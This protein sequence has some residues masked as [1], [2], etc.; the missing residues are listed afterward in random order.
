[1]DVYCSATH[2]HV[3]RCTLSSNQTNYALL[4]STLTVTFVIREYQYHYN[5]KELH[6]HLWN[7]LPTWCNWVFICVLSARHG[8]GLY[9]HLQEQW[10]LQFLYICCIWCPWCSK[11]SVL[12]SV[13]VLVACCTATLVAVEHATK[14]H[15][16]QDRHLTTQRTPYAAYVKK[17]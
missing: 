11:V 15:I 7:D 1:M 16:L 13:C 8:S 10:M 6:R 5:Q 12:R 3:F 14:T 17:L 2:D 4:G 9:A